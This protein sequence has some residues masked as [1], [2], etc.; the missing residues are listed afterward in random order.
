MQLVIMA[1]GLYMTSKVSQMGGK[2]YDNGNSYLHGRF[3]SKVPL[4]IFI[5]VCG[6]ILTYLGTVALS[7]PIFSPENRNM[8][9]LPVVSIGL[10]CGING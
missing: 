1:G 4:H 9:Y 6:V 2:A 3:L 5:W 7:Y 10:S 8:A